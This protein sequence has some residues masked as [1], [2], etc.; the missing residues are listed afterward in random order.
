MP[1]ATALCVFCRQPWAPNHG[2]T[3]PRRPTPDR[4]IAAMQAYLCIPVEQRADPLL[5]DRARLER[6][7]KERRAALLETR[8]WET[9]TGPIGLYGCLTLPFLGLAV[10]ATCWAAALWAVEGLPMLWGVYPPAHTWQLMKYSARAVLISGTAVLFG[11]ALKR[12]LTRLHARGKV[13][14]SPGRRRT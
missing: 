3:C 8:R 10:S 4:E 14:T 13:N 2:A 1:D 11:R 6:L 9:R 7:C 12:V 5:Q